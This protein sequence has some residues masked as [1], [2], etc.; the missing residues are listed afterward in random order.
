[1]VTCGLFPHQRYAIKASSAF[2]GLI[3]T[4]L[5]K[6]VEFSI[7]TGNDSLSVLRILRVVSLHYNTSPRVPKFKINSKLYTCSQKVVLI[8]NVTLHIMAVFTSAPA[9]INLHVIGLLSSPLPVTF[10]GAITKFV[11]N[12]T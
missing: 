2:H 8:S 12:E 3:K 5:R 4:S 6:C 7:G 9:S 1:M 10:M 11:N